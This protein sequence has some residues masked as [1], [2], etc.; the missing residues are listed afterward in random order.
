LRT[1]ATASADDAGFV[2]ALGADTVIDFEKERFEQAV[3]DVDAV[4]DLVG[5]ETQT[6]SFQV[7]RRGGKLI[8][9]VSAP[10]PGLAHRYGVE[11][12]FFL[13]KVTSERL[14]EL[15]ALFDGGK[16]RTHVGPVLPLAQAREAHLM[17]EG[18]RPRQKGKIVL[19]A[20]AEA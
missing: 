4:I 3:G 1:V 7:L 8:S 12:T 19:V 20:Q 14:A 2:R 15:A 9:A 13:V 5:G 11:A 6:R 16:L 17:L 18:M 10:D